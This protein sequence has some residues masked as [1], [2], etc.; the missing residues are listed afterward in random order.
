MVYRT[1]GGAALQWDPGRR[2]RKNGD[3]SEMA[4]GERRGL[5]SPP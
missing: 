3:A 5:L 1:S 4:G 2:N